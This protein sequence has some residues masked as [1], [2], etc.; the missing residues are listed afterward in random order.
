[1]FFL[2]ASQAKRIFVLQNQNNDKYSIKDKMQ[3][4]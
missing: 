1:M 4:Q 2:Y 3:S